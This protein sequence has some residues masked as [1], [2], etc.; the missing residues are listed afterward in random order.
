MNKIIALC[1]LALIWSKDKPAGLTRDKKYV[2]V[3][4]N[5]TFAPDLSNRVNPALYKRP[6]SDVDL[7]KVLSGNLYPTILRSKR[8]QNQK[9]RLLVDFINKGLIT[10]YN[11]NTD[12]MLLDFSRF[13]NQLSRIQYIQNLP[14][15]KPGLKQ[16]INSLTS[17]FGRVYSRAIKDNVG[18]D[19]WTYLDQ[20]I[21]DSHV[22][23][24]DPPIHQ[25]GITCINQYRNILM[26]PTDGYIEA[27]IFGK[28]FDLSQKTI[29]QFRKD[30]LASGE[31]DLVRYFKKA[32]AFHI[33]PARNERLKK[34]EILVVEMYDRSLTASGSATV[35]PTDMEIMRL[36]WTDWLQASGVK[37]F[38]FRP[39]ANSK[40]EAEKIILKF[41]GVN[42]I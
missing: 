15:A 19:I 16:D 13:P 20:G 42:K 2:I 37:R 18:A 31:V 35:H 36:F 27:G 8:T 1:L 12:K 25:D 34:L 23:E 21:N 29:N 5:I 11:V 6:L 39:Y 32:A 41:L 38:E 30:F 28:G 17:E 26:L 14:V 33:R 9:D 24:N 40:D 3:N 7:L 22:L 4:Y 10:K